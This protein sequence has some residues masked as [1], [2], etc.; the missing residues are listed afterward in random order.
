[1]KTLICIVS[2]VSTF[3]LGWVVYNPLER[4]QPKNYAQLA[5]EKLYV[6]NNAIERYYESEHKMPSSLTDLRIKNLISEADM[7]DPRS[8][9]WIYNVSND[10]C[11]VVMTS[12]QPSLKRELVEKGVSLNYVVQLGIVKEGKA[13]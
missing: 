2:F 13:Q 1:M 11:A 10:N 3:V 5:G 8:Q 4:N 6:L 9:S 7:T 12:R